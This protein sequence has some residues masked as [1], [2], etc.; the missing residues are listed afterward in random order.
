MTDGP[1]TLVDREKLT[2]VGDTCLFS[3]KVKVYVK[4][5]NLWLICNALVVSF[6]VL[7]CNTIQGITIFKHTKYLSLFFILTN[8]KKK[9]PSTPIQLSSYIQYP[10]IL[11]VKETIIPANSH[12]IMPYGFQ[13][14]SLQDWHVIKRL[15]SYWH[16]SWL[17]RLSHMSTFV[18]L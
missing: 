2:L 4:K 15:E 17:I 13:S 10:G 6:L 3:L 11:A 7:L 16:G 8:K 5:D 14:D 9:N 18:G 12:S 1:S